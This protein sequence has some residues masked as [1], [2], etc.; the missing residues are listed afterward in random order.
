MN[1][2]TRNLWEVTAHWRHPKV[3]DPLDKFM[4]FQ[5]WLL[6]YLHLLLSLTV[7]YF[8]H[9]LKWV[10]RHVLV[11]TTLG[12]VER[13]SENEE[14]IDFA[15]SVRSTHN[16]SLKL[17]TVVSF[18][19]Q[20]YASSWFPS[21]G[22]IKNLNGKKEMGW[23]TKPWSLWIEDA[24]KNLQSLR[25]ASYQFQKLQMFVFLFLSLRTSQKE[26]SEQK[27]NVFA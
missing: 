27:R 8:Q 3:Q 2:M 14:E 11:A 7:C 15:N 24:I 5:G 16:Y 25:R 19:Y 22:S 18:S 12:N 23:D 13:R 21:D 20:R 9:F 17:D 4:C 26:V 1:W 6:I 10:L